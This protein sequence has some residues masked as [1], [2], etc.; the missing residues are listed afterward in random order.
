MGIHLKERKPKHK[1]NVELLDIRTTE[2][3]TDNVERIDVVADEEEAGP[4]VVDA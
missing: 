3:V 2:V 4:P 1:I